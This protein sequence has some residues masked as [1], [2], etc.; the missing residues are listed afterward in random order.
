MDDP[1][2][3]AV[4]ASHNKVDAGDGEEVHGEGAGGEVENHHGVGGG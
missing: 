1:G 4:S 2:I 3:Q